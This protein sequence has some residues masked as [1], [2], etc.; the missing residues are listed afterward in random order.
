MSLSTLK[1]LMIPILIVGGLWAI[2]N[3]TGEVATLYTSDA[4]GQTYTTRIWV[5]DHG[6]ETW[7]RSLDPT[8][9]WLD[10][11]VNQPDVQ[12][13]RGKTIANFRATP[14]ADR[15]ARINA[16][17]AQRYGWAEWFL[18]R[19]ETRDAAVPVYLDPVS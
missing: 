4:A 13:R 17:M 14:H 8:S 5:V 1:L 15:R 3:F 11:I 9:P 18:S 10:R 16:L 6:H 12:L 19:I 2:R 7:I